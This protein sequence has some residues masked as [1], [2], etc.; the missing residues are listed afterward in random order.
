M[1]S[2][3]MSQGWFRTDLKSNNKK[4]EKFEEIVPIQFWS[5]RFAGI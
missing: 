4:G 5:G 2:F 1:L 3:N